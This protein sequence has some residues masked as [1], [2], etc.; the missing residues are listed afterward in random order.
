M[1]KCLLFVVVVC[2]CGNCDHFIVSAGSVMITPLL[3]WELLQSLHC[4]YGNYYNHSIVVMGITTITPLLIRSAII[5]LPRFIPSTT[6]NPGPILLKAGRLVN[7][8]DCS[9]M[10]RHRHENFIFSCFYV[11]RDGH[12]AHSLNAII[13]EMTL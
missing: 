11:F 1:F 13:T 12:S 2:W 7:F 4:C 10:K 9:L 6:N 5:E 3:L 8:L